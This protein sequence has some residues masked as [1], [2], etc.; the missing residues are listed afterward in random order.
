MPKRSESLLEKLKLG[1]Q[2]WNEVLSRNAQRLNDIL[3]KIDGL[4]DVDITGLATGDVLWWNASSQKFE[5][6]NKAYAISAG[7]VSSWSSESSHSSVS[8]DSSLSSDSSESSETISSQSESKESSYSSESSESTES[9]ESSS[10]SSSVGAADCG[11]WGAD[12]TTGETA[13]A[14]DDYNSAA[15]AI[16]GDTTHGW[17]S[18]EILPEWWKVQ[19]TTPANIERLR[20]YPYVNVDQ[21]PTAFEFQASNSGEF[22]GEEDV[23]LSVSGYTWTSATWGNWQFVNGQ[24]YRYYRIYITATNDENITR[25]NEIQMYQCDARSG[26]SSSESS[27]SSYSSSSS[28]FSACDAGW[29]ADRTNKLVTY[30]AQS[31][32]A[33]AYLAFDDNNGTTYTSNS[34]ASDIWIQCAFDYALT[35]RRFRIL[36]GGYPAV[37]YVG[38]RLRFMASNT[39]A[40]SGEQVTL[41]DTG[42]QA[43]YSEGTW[44]SYEF[45]NA[46]DY[47]YYR[48]RM[49]NAAQSGTYIQLRECEMF[50]CIDDS[51]SMSSESSYSSLSSYSSSSSES[52]P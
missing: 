5:N 44:Y 25:L 33:T 8:S 17:A 19:L 16:D 52:I 2:G 14:S 11:D 27:E 46:G 41:L 32:T 31:N 51:T 4:L 37:N 43:P 1:Q 49:S 26:S 50:E 42:V 30:S 45:T 3:L 13:T 21:H 34:G 7:S 10:S 9:I 36:T 29:T 15:W 28:L 22:A 23:L 48:L 47:L 18:D 39:G 38:R 35:I 12:L 6:V 40:F 24:E 20:I